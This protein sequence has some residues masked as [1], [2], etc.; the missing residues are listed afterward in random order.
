MRDWKVKNKRSTVPKYSAKYKLED[1]AAELEKVQSRFKRMSHDWKNLLKKIKKNPDNTI[2]NLIKLDGIPPNADIK[3][4]GTKL[5]QL[6]NKTRTGGQYEEIGSLYGFNLLIKTEVSEKDGTDIK[7]NRFFIQGEGNIKY[8]YN[9]GII[10][11]HEK[12]AASNFLNALE[13]IPSYIEQEQKKITEINKDLP[14]LQ[15]LVNSKWSKENRL[16]ELKTELASVERKI[17]LSIT[18]EAKEEIKKDEKEE[19]AL[20]DTS[21]KNNNPIRQKM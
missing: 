14:V 3:Q 2:V 15:E 1:Y 18:P 11:K 21:I 20:E 5:N 10:A 6:S 8:T 16:Y 12:L 4:I 17:Q 19:V 7:I 9:N 13:K